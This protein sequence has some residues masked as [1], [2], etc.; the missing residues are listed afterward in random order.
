VIRVTRIG[1]NPNWGTTT[2][3]Y[4]LIVRG[5][6]RAIFR[7]AI[8]FNVQGQQLCRNLRFCRG[9]CLDG[10]RKKIVLGQLVSGRGL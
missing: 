8:T 3:R 6:Y 4:L 10:L 7:L 5:A 9:V 1:S 2:M